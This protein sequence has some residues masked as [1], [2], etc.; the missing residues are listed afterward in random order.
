[1]PAPLFLLLCMALVSASCG[2]GDKHLPSSNP[3]EY[4]PKKVYTA[5][6]APPS[7]PA[8]VVKPTELELL[9]SKLDSLEVGQKVKGE[10][11]KVPF[12]PN[13]LQLFKG[14]TNPCEAL[15]KVA[16]GLGSTQLFA[17]NEGAALKKA[18]A[19]DADGI[20]RRM[21]EQLAEAFQHSLGPGAADCPILV[22]PEKKS[23][24]SQP[25]RLVLAHATSTLPVLLAQTTI[26]DTP[27]DDYEVQKNS[28]RENPPP[29]WVGWKTTDTMTRIGKEERPTKGIREDYEMIIAPKAKRCPN[30]AGIVDG[31]F[32]WSFMM[33]RATPEAQS[34][35]YRRKVRATL[36]G[37]V[38]D[39]A[40]LKKVVKFDAILTLQHIGTELSHYSESFGIQ[41]EF[42]IDQRRM[43][44]PQDLKIIT[45]SGFS[46]G[47]AQTKDAQLLGTLA[48]LMAYFSG[49]EY[50]NAQTE[51][52]RPN[53]CVEIAFTPATK[54]KK[55]VPSESTP[56]KT[57]LRT[58]KERAIVPAKF[59]EAKERP[60]EGNGRVSPREKES[61]PNTPATFTYRAPATR[62][63]HSGFW[64]VA[65]SRAGIAQA[66]DGEWELAPSSY[67]LEFKSHIVQEALNLVN[68]QF[69][70]FM[71][72]NGFDA[73]VEATVPLQHRDDGQWVGE[74]V[75][76]YATR[77]M[78]Q[79]AQ[80]EIRIQGT[81]T[82]TFHV[83]GGSI[84]M[85]PEPFAVNLVILPGQSGEV[86]ETHCTS[87]NTPEKL[88]ELLATQGVQGGDAHTVT[89]G[90]GWSGAFNFTRFRT[91]NW[92]KNG[93]EIGG[94]TQVLNSDVVAKK[95][96]RIN[97]SIGLSACQE[98]TTLILRM[99]DEPGAEASP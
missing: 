72:S 55:F 1:M 96:M 7:A 61:Q 77:T 36:K 5:P 91:F 46:E 60:R 73:H 6:A 65:V 2:G 49:Q 24:L 71:S 82:T 22:R 74:G 78:T 15:S 89:K 51:W 52:N 34:V 18:L 41:G 98:E 69:G 19:P 47:E 10:G 21:D 62:V 93:Y 67:V 87:G 59:N 3:P 23:G 86:A 40:Q 26:P 83:N 94:W 56:V 84:S 38:G 90:G 64:L 79:P 88:K 58:K 70:M 44:I 95:T 92:N 81:G 14:V 11:K 13:S 31:I 20:A 43:G 50:F 85:D 68:P 99:A 63:K 53:T 25:A 80:C 28:S 35:L 17:G 75:M 37:E 8:K 30:P 27:P 45:V 57:E 66:K 48:A 97:C 32:D 12:D 42:G 29:D 76:Q 9:R 16:Q 33:F 4:D 39:D 54:T